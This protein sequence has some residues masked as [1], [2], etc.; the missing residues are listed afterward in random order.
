MAP[1]MSHLQE[2][3]AYSLRPDG[4]TLFIQ[5][6]NIGSVSCPGLETRCFCK[7]RGYRILVKFSNFTGL[8]TC[9]QIHNVYFDQKG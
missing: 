5:T 8:K 7:V 4:K 9:F 2:N 3:Y 1:G 6:I